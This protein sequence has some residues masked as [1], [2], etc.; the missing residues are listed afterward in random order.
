MFVVCYFFAHGCW[1]KMNTINDQKHPCI[2]LAIGGLITFCGEITAAA[3]AA[4]LFLIKVSV[5]FSWQLL[6]FFF[7]CFMAN[8][9]ILICPSAFLKHSQGLAITRTVIFMLC[10]WFFSA[11][12]QQ[13]KMLSDSSSILW[14]HCWTVRKFC[15]RWHFS[16]WA[17][18]I[19][20]LQECL[21]GCVRLN[22][23][24]AGIHLTPLYVLPCVQTQQ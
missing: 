11:A 1:Y 3:A 21:S 15:I 17:Y 5:L 7:V 16:H 13:S 8:L 9:S 10:F 23:F 18:S 6:F 19:K 24:R 14:V 4:C 12:V 20:L 22:I 2:V